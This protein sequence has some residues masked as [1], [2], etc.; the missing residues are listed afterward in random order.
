LRR[1]PTARNPSRTKS[2][3]RNG[4]GP[5]ISIVPFSGAASATSHTA[6]ATS[7]AAIG[8]ISTGGTRTVSPSV[9][10]S[11]MRAANSKNCVA[12]TIEYGMDEPWMSFSWAIFAL[13]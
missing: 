10:S 2:S 13:M 3:N 4:S 8:W 7:S 6:A 9:A 11:V 12:C 1:S 5:P